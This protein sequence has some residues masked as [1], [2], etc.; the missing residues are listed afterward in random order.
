ALRRPER[1]VSVLDELRPM[2]DVGPIAFAEV[3][4][5]LGR[6]LTELVVRAAGRRAGK[7]YVAPLESARGLSFDAVFVPGLAEK[8]FPQKVSEDPI[9]HDA[10]RK[11]L[12]RGL[13]TRD[14]RVAAERLALRVAVGAPR[15]R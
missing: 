9:L 10:S 14:D 5:V 8:L 6:R 12:D 7:V 1:V 13:V 3:R 4:L 11:V 2:A 15:E